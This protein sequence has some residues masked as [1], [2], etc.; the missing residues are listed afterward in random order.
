[1]RGLRVLCRLPA[2]G[3]ASGLGGGKS[4]YLHIIC[5]DIFWLCSMQLAECMFDHDTATEAVE[6]INAIWLLAS[7]NDSA[8]GASLSVAASLATAVMFVHIWS[9]A[10]G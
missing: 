9:R 4:W 7:N 2:C 10:M 5:D 8:P 6:V 3:A 1:M